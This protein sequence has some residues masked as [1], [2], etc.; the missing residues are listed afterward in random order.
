MR[1]NSVAYQKYS[2]FVAVTSISV[3]KAFWLFALVPLYVR[4]NGL[5]SVADCTVQDLKFIDVDTVSVED[6]GIVKIDSCIILNP[7]ID[8]DPPVTI[9]TAYPIITFPKVR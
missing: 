9:V 1:V 6:A 4:V 3:E 8:H 2:G 7:A 5:D